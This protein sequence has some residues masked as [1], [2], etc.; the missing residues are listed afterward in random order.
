M[1]E[2]DSFSEENTPNVWKRRG[3]YA[4]LGLVVFLL[5]L[6]PMWV[7]TREASR[8]LET[9]Q[10]QLR[11]AEIK[12]LLTT[13]IVEA[14][15]GEYES[16]RQN[17]SEFYTRLRAEIDKGDE[18]A[19]TKEE[20]AKMNPVFDNR[21][22]MITLL[23]QRDQASVERL[24]DVYSTYQQILGQ[25]AAPPTTTPAPSTSSAPPSSNQPSPPPS[26]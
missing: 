4:L 7:Q 2:E 5:G 10:K 19:Y 11:K 15:R 13:S 9:T 16:A 1:K 21:D 17:T 23:A 20:R 22:A 8:Q 14:R 3:I 24:T 26:P 18:S 12:G 25:P 6:V